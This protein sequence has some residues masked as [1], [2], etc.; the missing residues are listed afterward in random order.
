MFNLRKTL[1]YKLLM[2]SQIGYNLLK[3]TVIKIIFIGTSIL[4]NSFIYKNI[5]H[6]NLIILLLSEIYFKY[7]LRMAM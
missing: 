2:M 1:H 7:Y 4:I 5:N 6:S 3:S